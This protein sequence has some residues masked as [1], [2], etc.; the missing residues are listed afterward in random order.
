MESS[1]TCASARVRRGA[2]S[3]SG[4]ARGWPRP[5]R[6]AYF[7]AVVLVVRLR[8]QNVDVL[9]VRHFSTMIA[10]SAVSRVG[11]C[12]YL[13]RQKPSRQDSRLVH[14]LLSVGVLLPQVHERGCSRIRGLPKPLNEVDMQTC[15][16]A[17]E[18]SEKTRGAAPRREG[19]HSLLMYDMPS[20]PGRERSSMCGKTLHTSEMWMKERRD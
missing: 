10:E 3:A 15:R 11:R 12:Q 20:V 4:R 13:G 7:D 6:E 19:P 2:K 14:L 17:R 18:V 1:V 8:R 9:V 5:D 16:C